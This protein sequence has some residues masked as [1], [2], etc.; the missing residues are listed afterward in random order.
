MSFPS[1][2]VQHIYAHDYLKLV[3]LIVVRE[4][5]PYGHVPYRIAFQELFRLDNE[6]L[7][8]MT[9]NHVV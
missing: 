7:H 8:N 2:R 4:R 6:S 1:S 9:K 3:L 5:L